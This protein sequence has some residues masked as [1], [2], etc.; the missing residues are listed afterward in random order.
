MTP[1]RLWVAATVKPIFGAVLPGPALG[2][3]KLDRLAAIEGVHAPGGGVT[4]WSGTPFRC[5]STRV[6]LHSSPPRRSRHH[7]RSKL[8]V[9]TALTLRSLHVGSVQFT[10]IQHMCDMRRNSADVHEPFQFHP[11]RALTRRF[12][13][14]PAQLS[15][16]ERIFSERCSENCMSQ[17]L[18]ILIHSFS[19][20]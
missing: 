9:H 2:G 19:Q 4:C 17:V 12:S 20:L 8:P 5:S 15:V 1:L 7:P 6:R 16:G 18:L 13:C 10:A 11:N 3:P 14:P